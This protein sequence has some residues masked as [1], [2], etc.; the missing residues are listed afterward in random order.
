MLKIFSCF[1]LAVIANLTLSLLICSEG[2]AENNPVDQLN[3]PKEAH[4][5]ND[6]NKAP[7]KK[8]KVQ[9][10]I[11]PIEVHN[12][13]YAQRCFDIGFDI[14]WARDNK[15]YHPDDLIEI[16]NAYDYRIRSNSTQEKGGLYY[17]GARFFATIYQPFDMSHFPFDRQT[18]TVNLED[19]V[20]G[21]DELEF[22]IDETVPLHDSF[23][24]EGWHLIKCS[25][26]S[27][28]YCYPTNFGI[29]GKITTEFSRTSLVFEIKREGTRLFFSYFLGFFVS[30]I[31]S[32]LTYIIRPEEGNIK[33][34][35]SLASI[36]GV[37]GN[38]Y[39]IDNFL[40]ITTK[41][42]LCDGIEI[43]TF[44]FIM[45]TT[46]HNVVENTIYRQYKVKKI[47]R[48][49]MFI[50]ISLTCSYLISVG[51]FIINAIYS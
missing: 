6:K 28:P 11:Y 26:K 23:S 14:W 31:L 49:N 4:D 38:K 19:T 34:S 22:V 20:F 41:F 45:V 1:S 18:L 12:F 21:S 5:L 17:T 35:L 37:I 3:R 27:L 9:C 51:Y 10:G 47:K 13:N 42:T 8:M 50:C 43:A 24:L 39:I 16:T 36:F 33:F 32:L 46:V 30:V 40:P 44:I 7:R 25:L 15:D 2:W 48:M 29:P